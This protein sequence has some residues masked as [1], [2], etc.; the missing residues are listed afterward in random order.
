MSAAG[1]QGT[2]RRVV[3]CGASNVTLSLPTIVHHV[4]AGFTGPVQMDIADGHGRSY[5]DWTN[6]L[7]RKVPGHREGEVSDLH[8]F[9]HRHALL[10]DIGNDLVYG[11]SVQQ[12]AG[13]VSEVAQRLADQSFELTITGLPL[14]SVQSLSKARFGFFRTLFFPTSPLKFDGLQ[15]KVEEL[16]HLVRQIAANVGAAVVEPKGDWYGLDPIHI[17]RKARPAAWTEVFEQWKT[18]NPTD[19]PSFSLLR[20]L[21]LWRSKPQ[22]QQ[23]FGKLRSHQRLVN[24]DSETAIRFF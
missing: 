22:K 20:K 23:V 15:T 1:T 5:G 3:I 18:W 19:I 7:F 21:T 11:V 12:I 14:A 16:N 2:G 4:R 9:E 10:T 8:T 24:L 17:R 13:W 6:V